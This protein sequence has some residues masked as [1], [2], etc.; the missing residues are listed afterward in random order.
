MTTQQLVDANWFKSSYSNNQGGNCVE[1]AR[2]GG[3]VM[4]V[5]DSKDPGQGVC[6]FPAAAWGAFVAEVKAAD[7]VA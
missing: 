6:V 4:A 3:R 5:R 7:T 2:L 1:G